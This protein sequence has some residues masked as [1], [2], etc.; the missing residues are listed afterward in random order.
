MPER[1]KRRCRLIHCPKKN[2]FFDIQNL[3]NFVLR[4]IQDTAKFVDQFVDMLLIKIQQIRKNVFII[5][6]NFLKLILKQTYTLH[7]LYSYLSA[8]SIINKKI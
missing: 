8:V 4:F 2:L 3:Q 7:I 6:L 5:F 1:H